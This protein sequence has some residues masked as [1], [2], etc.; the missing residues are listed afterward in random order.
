MITPFDCGLPRTI[1][2]RGGLDSLSEFSEGSPLF[3][4]PRPLKEFARHKY[5]VILSA[6]DEDARR[7]STETA[8]RAADT[9]RF[10]V[11]L[12]TQ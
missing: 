4:K 7:T 2:V 12:P 8:L 5:V 6:S 10:L 11:A 9:R 1:L 3:Q